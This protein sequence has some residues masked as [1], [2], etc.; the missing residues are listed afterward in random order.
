ML[1]MGVI[2]PSSSEWCSPVVLVPKK[3]GSTRFCIDFRRLNSVAKFDAY[4]MPSIDDLLDSLGGD[5][6][7]SS[8]DLTRGYWQIPLSEESQ[9]KTAFSTPQGLFEFVIMPF[10]LSGAPA[11]FQRMMN[12][13]LAGKGD[14]AKAYLDDLVIFSKTW[15]DHLQHIKL[16]LQKLKEEHLTAKPSKC[17]LGMR[18]TPY[19]CY[20]VGNDTVQPSEGKVR[21]IQEIPQTKTKKDVRSFLGL[22]SYYRRFIQNMA[23]VAAPLS[24]C[25]KKRAPNEVVWTGECEQAFAKLKS[26]LASKPLLQNPNFEKEFIVQTDAS[27]RGLGAVLSQIG[28]DGQEP[29]IA[30]SRAE[31]CCGRVGMSGYCLGSAGPS[32]VSGWSK[33]CSGNRPP[34]PELHAADGQQE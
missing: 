21:S 28:P 27:G 32:G 30:S 8:L 26:Q 25:T 3:D 24:D 17:K 13:L 20:V 7:I 10:G 11:T 33:V 15:E 2:Q 22:V 4:P 31:I 19:L 18:E 1:K 29:Q 34:S 12:Q 9:Q 5:K 16:V 6:F 23:E 14:F